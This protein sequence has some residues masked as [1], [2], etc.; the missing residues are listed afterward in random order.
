MPRWNS[1]A[2]RFPDDQRLR[3]F[4]FTIHA[5]PRGRQAVWRAPDGELFG[6]KEAL[7]ETWI[8]QRVVEVARTKEGI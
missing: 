5:R 8:R 2:N 4:G 7:A 3:G 6:E 1:N